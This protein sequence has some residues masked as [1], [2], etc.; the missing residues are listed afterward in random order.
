MKDE[1]QLY[2]DDDEEEEEEM[3][4]CDYMFALLVA[5]EMQN[6]PPTALTMSSK[7]VAAV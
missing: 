1:D 6:Q 7:I 3:I 5:K 4:L 2:N